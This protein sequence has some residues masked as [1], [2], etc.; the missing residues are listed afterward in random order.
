[1]AEAL[2]EFQAALETKRAL[3]VNVA[4]LEACQP[5]AEAGNPH[6]RTHFR[7]KNSKN[8]LDSK[9]QTLGD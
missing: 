8:T 1:M 7:L 5:G 9:G 2:R 3:S 4:C 6:P